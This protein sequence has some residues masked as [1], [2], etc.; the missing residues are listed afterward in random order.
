MHVNR[1]LSILLL[2]ALPLTAA[3]G[4]KN[5]DNAPSNAAAALQAADAPDKPASVGGKIRTAATTKV[6][7]NLGAYVSD[8]LGRIELYDGTVLTDYENPTGFTT[9]AL[10]GDHGGTDIQSLPVT[11]YDASTGYEQCLLFLEDTV[12]AITARMGGD[13]Q[14]V[15]RMPEEKTQDF[16]D[17]LILS[18]PAA[19]EYIKYEFDAYFSRDD[20]AMS[21]LSVS[22]GDGDW[23][24]MLIG[25][26]YV[27]DMQQLCADTALGA[28]SFALDRGGGS[29]YCYVW[30]YGNCFYPSFS[31]V[32]CGGVSITPDTVSVACAHA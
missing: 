26:A 28:P 25:D 9:V 23:A 1:I 15:G 16:H 30:E 7:Y 21:L 2:C 24:G 8:G 14:A 31:D 11:L 20:K 27:Y 12:D 3:C 17:T 10:A 6:T 4:S 29:G 32:G 5:A 18:D 22:S 13:V 19:P